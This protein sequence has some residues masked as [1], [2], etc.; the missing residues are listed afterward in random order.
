MGAPLSKPADAN[1]VVRLR[2]NYLSAIENVAQSIGTMGPVATIG[3]ILPLLIYKSGNGTWL[4][5]LG[6]LTAFCLIAANINVFASR[7]ASAGSL[8]T[9]AQNGLGNGALGNWAG[10]LT[11]W[12]YVVALI[13]VATSS[14]VSSA[15]YFAIL[16][17][18]FTGLPVGAT[19]SIALTVLVA[20]LAWWPAHR[21]VKLST[22]MM[23]GAESFS[24]LLILVI[25]FAAMLRVHHWVDRSQLRLEGAGFSHYQLG[26]VLAFMTLAGFES[27]TALG[28]EA[29]TA[30]RTL[31]RVMILCI[32]PIG[33]LFI[34]SI[35]CMTAL[36]HSLNLAL[37]Q[38]DGPLDM[39]ARSVGLPTLGWLSSL[40]V[41][42]SC[43]GCSLGGFN[44]GSRVV[45][46][47]AR[48]GQ[49]WR[50]FNAVHPVN[51]TPH[52]ALTLF[53]G[54]SIA[55]PCLMIGSGVSMANA[56]DYLMQIAALGFLGGYLLV[57]LAA[58]V[59]LASQGGLRLH[60][61][62]AAIL[63]MCILGAVL[64]LSL[65]PV[66]PGP[67]RYLPYT[68]AALLI[69]GMLFSGRS[70]VRRPKGSSTVD[71]TANP[72]AQLSDAQL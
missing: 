67:S 46:S 19:G 20:L 16:L 5:F 64:L 3:T 11:G 40:G 31:P 52:R 17:T 68:F 55:V 41:A 69:I 53:A 43:F 38:T 49:I 65:V 21:D 56:M 12:S 59:Y 9:F 47:M 37:D 33:L 1:G 6:V 15:Y 4:L 61:L 18:H 10:R 24:V 32:L 45:Y 42:I 72:A 50:W 62:A 57:C 2:R 34:G 48:K 35:Y 29:K 22:K 58:P 51:G 23:L 25:L 70:W 39:I 54:I 30:T 36:S 44:A 8:A 27:V 66:P 7:F 63:T 71:A 14:G 13:F 28:E 26:F 60:Q